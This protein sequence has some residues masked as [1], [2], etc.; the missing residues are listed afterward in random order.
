MSDTPTRL[1]EFTCKHCG[2][3]LMKVERIRDPEITMLADHLRA[4]IG[5]DRP[6]RAGPRV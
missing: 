1:F 3:S 2:H 5:S 4:C 6:A